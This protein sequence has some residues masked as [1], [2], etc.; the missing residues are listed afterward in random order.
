[1]FPLSKRLFIFDF[2]LNANLLFTILI[3]IPVIQSP[4]HLHIIT[5]RTHCA[6]LCVLYNQ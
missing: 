2:K 4:T 1:M 3:N 5:N 6:Y